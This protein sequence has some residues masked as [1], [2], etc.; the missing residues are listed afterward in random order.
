MKKKRFVF[1]MF[2]ILFY[3]IVAAKYQ[4]F[5]IE[6]T[7]FERRKNSSSLLR[8]SYYVESS[9]PKNACLSID[10]DLE[11][12]VNKTNQILTLFPMKGGGKTAMERFTK[13]CLNYHNHNRGHNRNVS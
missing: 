9:S 11:S 1:S 6:H 3:C 8:E 5:D 7:F 10:E 12:L 13:K 4:K 2:A